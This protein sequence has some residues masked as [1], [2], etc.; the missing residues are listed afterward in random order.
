MCKVGLMRRFARATGP[1]LAFALI[2]QL[3]ATQERSQPPLPLEVEFSTPVEG[4]TDVRLDTVI[5]VQFSRDVDERSFADRVKVAYAQTDSAERGEAQP[6]ALPFAVRYFAD[7]RALQITPTKPL[8]RFRPVHVE[9]LEGVVGIDGSKLRHWTLT[10]ST[11][12]SDLQVTSY[13]LQVQ[14]YRFT[15]HQCLNLELVTC[16]LGSSDFSVGGHC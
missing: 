5:R 12:G 3:V 14:S 11:G 1:L 16:N 13:K 2:Q 9:L 4:E 10:F 15:T 8:E 6:P 7:R